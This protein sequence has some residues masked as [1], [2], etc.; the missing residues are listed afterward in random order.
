MSVV[1]ASLK[2]F[3]HSS[4]QLL[5]A[6]LSASKPVNIVIGNQSAGMLDYRSYL[7]FGVRLT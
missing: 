7:H 5:L 4:R 6:S 3:L 1:R 2:Q